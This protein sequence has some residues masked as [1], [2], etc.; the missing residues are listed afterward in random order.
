[1]KKDNVSEYLNNLR[2]NLFTIISVFNNLNREFKKN[3][4]LQCKDTKK[5]IRDI[6]KDLNNINY[7]IMQLNKAIEEKV[8]GD[9]L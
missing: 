9:N 4:I 6:E 3:N 7:K 5:I 2:G 1:M 8:Q